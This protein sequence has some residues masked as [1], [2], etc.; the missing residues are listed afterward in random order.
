MRAFARL[1][2]ALPRRSRLIWLVLCSVLL[3]PLAW[4]AQPAATWVELPYCALAQRGAG[5]AVDD[6]TATPP[7]HRAGHH[8]AAHTLLVLLNPAAVGAGSGSLLAPPPAPGLQ[9]ALA[10]VGCRLRV[11]PVAGLRLQPRA[12]T[13]PPSRAPP[14]S[15]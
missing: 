8:G 10:G 3:Q 9:P 14:F 7:A 2:P 15:F 11:S 12:H 4:A 13:T 6:S 1:L 5:A